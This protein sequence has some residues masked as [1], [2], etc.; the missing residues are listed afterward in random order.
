MYTLLKNK[1]LK[2]ITKAEIPALFTSL[3]F[4]ETL[5]HFGSFI[6]ECA[7]FVGT[8]LAISFVITNIM[9]FSTGTG[10]KENTA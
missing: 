9:S 10:K 2:K 8:W 1:E 5:Y 6:L 4:T 7:A 3:I